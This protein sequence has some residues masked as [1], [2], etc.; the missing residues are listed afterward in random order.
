MSSAA[1]AAPANPQRR[2]A[3]AAAAFWKPRTKK[4]LEHIQVN[5][6]AG[7][8]A[9]L[10]ASSGHAGGYPHID[11]LTTPV[12][13]PRGAGQGHIP[14]IPNLSS[15]GT[16]PSAARSPA[17]A[18]RPNSQPPPSGNLTSGRKRA[19]D[20][21]VQMQQVY[22]QRSDSGR[23]QSAE[24]LP[25]GQ[26]QPQSPQ[27]EFPTC[28]TP[29]I[30][31]PVQQAERYGLESSMVP[32][33]LRIELGDFERWQVEPINSERGPRYARAVQTTTLEKQE[34]TILSF[35][36]Y[37]SHYFC[38]S[39][40]GLALFAHP[41]KVAAFLGYIMARGVLK[42]HVLKHISLARKVNNYLTSGAGA[43]SDIRQHAAD[44][45]AWLAN[46]EAQ[47]SANMPA[48][49][50]RQIP[51][52]R[53]MWAWVDHLVDGALADVG[54]AMTSN[55]GFTVHTALKVQRALV[56]ALVTGRYMPPCRI[57]L[58]K[59]MVHP[60]YNGACT[61]P[62]CRN[63]THCHGNQIQVLERQPPD[64]DAEG[65]EQVRR[66]LGGWGRGLMGIRRATYPRNI[67]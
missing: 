39:A 8:W 29:T 61:D 57:H 51:L 40:L 32:R 56:A 58:I 20:P 30:L 41:R 25:R 54:H 45:D 53:D 2:M 28:P 35:L 60:R 1:P 26:A 6:G 52:A 36:G 14:G 42:G 19:R 33:A 24:R 65:D 11:T 13:I 31:T 46:M 21:L 47:V 34:R 4:T 50:P 15:G 17:T 59:T 10:W 48:P 16:R 62:D 9:G 22:P 64:S 37:V 66:G 38:G 44:M 63:M 23:P 67:Q 7:V 3:E 43:G 18:A 27:Q 5:A 49:P 12:C 55:I